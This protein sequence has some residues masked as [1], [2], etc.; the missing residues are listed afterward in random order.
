MTTKQKSPRT[1][2]SS[3]RRNQ[4]VKLKLVGVDDLQIAENLNITPSRVKAEYKKALRILNDESNDAVR[5]IRDTVY[6][7]YENLLR[8]LYPKVLLEPIDYEAL[9]GVLRIIEGERKLFGIDAEQTQINIDARQQTFT[10]DETQDYK[11]ELKRRIENY[12]NKESN[13]IDEPAK[14]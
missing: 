10:L 1:L 6:Q 2:A 8:T 13:V 5:I 14:N 3:V 9:G 11:K 12:L 4:I 7:R